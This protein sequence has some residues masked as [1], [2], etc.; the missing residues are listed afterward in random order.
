MSF[1]SML[2]AGK[3]KPSYVRV[4]RKTETSDGMGGSTITDSILHRR[5]LCRFNAMSANA[6]AI[7][8][9]KS[10]V[11]ADYTVYMEYVSGIKEGDQLI[12]E[13]DAKTYDIKLIMDWDKDNAMLK[14]AVSETGRLE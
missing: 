11:R 7:L 4:S 12:D 10:A 2:T 6:I 1:N 5:L 14:L 13:G 3:G 9:D 8:W